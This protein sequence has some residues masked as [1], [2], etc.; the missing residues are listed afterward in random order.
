MKIKL[1]CSQIIVL[2]I[3]LTNICLA[4][5]SV[6]YSKEN[7]L[8]IRMDAS[9]S[10]EKSVDYVS[11]KINYFPIDSFSQDIISFETEPAAKKNTDSYEFYWKNPEPGK[12]DL[13]IDSTVKTRNT[14]LPIKT[15]I[16]FPLEETETEYLKATDK[17]DINDDIRY[18]ASLIADG[19]DDLFIVAAKLA[20]WSKDNINYTLDTVTADASQKASWVLKNRYGVCDEITNLFI[21][22]CRS[23][24]IPAR[25]VS[26]ISYTNSDLFENP[27]GLHGWAEVYF[28][29]YGWVSFDPTYGQY[30]YIDAGHI[31]LK[32]S[33]DSDK[34]S[35][36][37][38]WQGDSKL[39][40]MPLDITVK[41]DVGEKAPDA[42]SIDASPYKNEVGYGSYNLIEV[43]LK[44]LKNHYVA[45]DLDINA[46]KEIEHQGRGFIVMQPNEQKSFYFLI[47]VS[48][49]LSDS[50]IY[51]F[52]IGI[53]SSLGTKDE[54]SFR[55]S[56][57]AAMISKSQ[58][59]VIYDS[60]S[61]RE[62]KTYS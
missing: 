43:R 62:E 18:Q 52:P 24:G 19:E 36:K 29:D 9:F 45:F 49:R 61:E 28:Q 40:T 11:A 42:I 21:A 41:A 39:D 22:M 23:L 50:Y 5:E 4:Q 20:H 51:T 30:G 56:K 17:I 37:F 10:L 47:K 60:L 35:T 13:I 46:P 1:I 14:Y 27:W 25:F 3:L 54:T 15:K 26:G 34:T 53:S 31:K 48:D 44:N 12:Y 2:L 7:T 58:A 16:G 33:I 8:D 32:D 55:S 6:L 38:E 57:N 59:T